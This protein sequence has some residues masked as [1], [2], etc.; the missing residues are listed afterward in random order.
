M[1]KRYI[2]LLLCISLIGNT[3]LA[4]MQ[5]G[6]MSPPELNAVEKAGIKKYDADRIVKKLKIDDDSIKMEITK[7][8]QHYNQEMDHLLVLHSN[9]LKDLESEFD[10]NVKIAMQNRDKSQMN[11]TKARIER[12]IPPIRTEVQKHTELL[13]GA[14]EELL[15]EKQY[16]KCLKYFQSF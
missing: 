15:T 2:S 6:Q 3:I 8:V 5:N 10:R 13:I 12:I 14:F 7:H 4:Q 1:N 9:E 16:Q 11:G